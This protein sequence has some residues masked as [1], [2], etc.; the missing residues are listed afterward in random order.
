MSDTQTKS[1]IAPNLR[2]LVTPI[3]EL[4]EHPDNPRRGDV[5][6]IAESFKRFGQVK[7]IVAQMDG[8]VIA[9]NHSLQAARDE[10]EKEFD[11]RGDDEMDRSS[12]AVAVVLLEC[13]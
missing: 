5:T 7:P 13:G 3:T 6:V 11:S 12:N 8:T 4:K 10:L 9:G 1:N 2:D